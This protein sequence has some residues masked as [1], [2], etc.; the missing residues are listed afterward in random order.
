M[1][2]EDRKLLHLVAMKIVWPRGSGPSCFSSENLL[3]R[4]IEERL[5]RA[6]DRVMIEDYLV[7][8]ARFTARAALERMTE[9]ETT[10]TCGG[11]D[12]NDC[13]ECNP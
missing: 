10:K 11:C 3:D 8:S 13:P 12:S 2:E 4:A 7:T 1:T 9:S 5:E 6:L